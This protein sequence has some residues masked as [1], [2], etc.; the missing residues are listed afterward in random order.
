MR[1]FATCCLQTT[2]QAL[3]FTTLV[4]C[5]GFAVF[6]LGSMRSTFDFGFLTSF[7]LAVA[8]LVD[9][10]L[11]PA[12]VVLLTRLRSGPFTAALGSKS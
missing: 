9:I 1:R 4:L 8:F 10:L 7:A 2:G 12:L 11:A 6:T 3:L 5:A